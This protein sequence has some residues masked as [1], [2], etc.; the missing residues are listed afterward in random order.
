MKRDL[1][2]LNLH[3]AQAPAIESRQGHLHY[4][5]AAMLREVVTPSPCNAQ[6]RVRSHPTRNQIHDLAGFVLPRGSRRT[7]SGRSYE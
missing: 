7:Q 3:L 4:N 5:L 1:G 6:S 2:G